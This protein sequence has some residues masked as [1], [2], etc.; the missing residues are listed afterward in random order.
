MERV[1]DPARISIIKA[2]LEA[3]ADPTY[4]VERFEVE[5]ADGHRVL[6]T[7][8]RGYIPPEATREAAPE[9]PSGEPESAG[10]ATQGPKP[11]LAQVEGEHEIPAPNPEP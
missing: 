10:E 4:L 1:E 5:E 3:G 9:A 2:L 7:L 11:A 6:G 8:V